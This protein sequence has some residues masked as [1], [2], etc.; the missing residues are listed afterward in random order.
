MNYY[1][2]YMGDYAKA[3]ARLGMM[4]HG[5]YALLLDYYYASEMPLPKEI[6]EVYAIAKASSP[7]QRKAVS[8]VL[9]LFFHESDDGWHQSRADEEIASSRQAIEK[10]RVSGKEAAQKRWN[11]DRST[12]RSTNGSTHAPSSGLSMGCGYNHQPPTTNQTKKL[13]PPSQL[14]PPRGPNRLRVLRVNPN[15][16]PKSSLTLTGSA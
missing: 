6:R 10:Q 16:T 5:A 14:E 7:A 2:R 3:T 11:G 15:P 8:R 13:H 9:N 1:R 4:E 12:H